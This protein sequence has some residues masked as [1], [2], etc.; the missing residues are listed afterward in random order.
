MFLLGQTFNTGHKFVTTFLNLQKNTKFRGMFLDQFKIFKYQQF[1]DL[2]T[3]VQ[4]KETHSN[5]V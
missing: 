3:I 5:E 1:Y 4:I 2:N